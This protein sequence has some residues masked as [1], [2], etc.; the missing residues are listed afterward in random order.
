[1][2]AIRMVSICYVGD[3]D[4]TGTIIDETRKNPM[5][6][7]YPKVEADAEIARLEKEVEHYRKTLAGRF[8]R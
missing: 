5:M 3:D 8:S 6:V 1:M 2:E 7:F 4:K